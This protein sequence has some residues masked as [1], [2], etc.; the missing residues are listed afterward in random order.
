M[1]N[2]RI[3]FP[4]P[5]SPNFYMMNFGVFLVPLLLSIIVVAT[6]N[7]GEIAYQD[8]HETNFQ[9]QD[10][11]QTKKSKLLVTSQNNADA[12]FY[13]GIIFHFGNG[14]PQDVDKALD[15]YRLAADQGHVD[16]QYALGEMY[17][18]GDGIPQNS[19]KAYKWIR[20][21]AMQGDSDAQ[22]YLGR[23]YSKK[24]GK[25]AKFLVQAHMWFNITASSEKSQIKELATIERDSLEL[26]M[27]SRQIRRANKMAQDWLERNS[28][29]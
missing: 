13:L 26:W 5:V 20:L 10:N 12:Q 19:A 3:K 23:I 24:R 8:L 21:A 9:S 25:A 11:S 28:S 15:W 4:G 2:S 22:Y 27:T 17:F 18:Y 14:V 16:A 29:N 6:C 1:A 7:A